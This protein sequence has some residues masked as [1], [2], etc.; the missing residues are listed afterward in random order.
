[1]VYSVV[2]NFQGFCRV[3]STPNYGDRNLVCVDPNLELGRLTFNLPRFLQG[4]V[5]TGNY[6]STA[7]L[8]SLS[9]MGQVENRNHIS[10]YSKYIGFTS[11]TT[12]HVLS[13]LLLQSTIE[14]EKSLEIV[15]GLTC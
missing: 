13:M 4:M 7:L 8:S 15:S 5:V 11:R 6:R 14:M 1:M 9:Y 2:S 3:L 10:F 12:D